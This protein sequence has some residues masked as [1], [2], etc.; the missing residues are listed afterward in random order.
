METFKAVILISLNQEKVNKLSPEELQRRTHKMAKA[1]RCEVG[2]RQVE[3][4]QFFHWRAGPGGTPNAPWKP[5]GALV[6]LEARNPDR[7]GERIHNIFQVVSHL[8]QEMM[9]L[10][11]LGDLDSW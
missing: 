9:V 11:P 10:E 2:V 8:D 7:L 3:G 5:H 6:F 1:I 4:V